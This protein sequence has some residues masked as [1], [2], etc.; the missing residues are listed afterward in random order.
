GNGIILQIG[1][2]KVGIG[3]EEEIDID[4]PP[5]IKNDRTMVPI[6]VIAEIFNE[7][8]IWEEGTKSVYIGEI[9]KKRIKGEV[10]IYVD[11]IKVVDV[12]LE[13]QLDDILL[14]TNEI[15]KARNDGLK[16]YKQELA[17][18][19]PKEELEALESIGTFDP[20]GLRFE[21]KGEYQK[22][23]AYLIGSHEAYLMYFPKTGEIAVNSFDEKDDGKY[24]EVYNRYIKAEPKPV[25]KDG[26]IYIPLKYLAR[27]IRCHYSMD[28]DGNIH[29]N[30]IR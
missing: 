4:V 14:P 26:K 16:Y 7:K 13:G 8:V 6:R 10:S 11:E 1:S 3:E 12:K 27:A 29:L 20:Y 18:N 23:D 22:E 21:K 30:G 2:D 28:S 19:V 9:P 15:L 17:K 25:I 5:E 24:G